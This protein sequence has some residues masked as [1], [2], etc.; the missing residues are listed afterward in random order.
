MYKA[1]LNFKEI[2]KCERTLG[3]L[4]L[5]KIVVDGPSAFFPKLDHWHNLLPITYHQN[6]MP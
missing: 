1:K 6:K 2:M 4:I 3:L 5:V